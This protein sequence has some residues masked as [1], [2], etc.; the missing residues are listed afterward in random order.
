MKRIL[1]LFAI[2]IMIFFHSSNLFS[3]VYMLPHGN[4]GGR[5]IAL[6]NW[7]VKD[8]KQKISTLAWDVENFAYNSR[9][10][11]TLDDA[12]VVLFQEKAQNCNQL[13]A[14]LVNHYKP[15][16]IKKKAFVIFLEENQLPIAVPD[17][18]R[19]IFGDNI[20]QLQIKAPK[21]KNQY[22]FDA[23]FRNYDLI[24]DLELQ[25]LSEFLKQSLPTFPVSS[26]ISPTASTSSSS[27]ST[28]AQ[29]ARA[30]SIASTIPFAEQASANTMLARA[31]AE[32]IFNTIR[33][34]LPLLTDVQLN[35]LNV[36]IR[37]ELDKRKQQFH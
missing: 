20:Y 24:P 10:L 33:E 16:D 21:E 17:N 30:E 23:N 32:A 8:L 15:N 14:M 13:T 19:L 29:Q 6:N 4:I 34:Q 5:D 27:S 1:Q 37:S 7:V 3:T 26:T 36:R 9:I 2:A 25:R 18:L 12:D 35:D 28:T 31:K 22:I 11:K